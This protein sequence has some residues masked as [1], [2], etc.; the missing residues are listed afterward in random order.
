MPVCG[1][2]KKGRF[3]NEVGKRFAW[4]GR[5]LRKICAVFSGNLGKNSE[6]FSGRSRAVLLKKGGRA[7]CPPFDAGETPA[8]PCV[9][10]AYNLAVAS[11]LQGEIAHIEVAAEGDFEDGGNV[12][13]PGEEFRDA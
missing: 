2:G 8:L 12:T 1:G 13:N 6:N 5:M 10:G 3:G 11:R 7:S 4:W 9:L